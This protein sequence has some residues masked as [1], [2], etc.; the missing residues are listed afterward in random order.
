MEKEC[1]V[2]GKKFVNL[3]VHIRKLHKMSKEDY[4]VYEKGTEIVD[5]DNKEEV[6]DLSENQFK[7]DD[8][9]IV[10][11]KE[12]DIINNVV[13]SSQIE[14]IGITQKELRKNMLSAKEEDPNELLSDF[15]STH[16]VTK[17]EVIELINRYQHGTPIS[18]TQVTRQKMNIYKTQASEIA[19]KNESVL[20]MTNVNIVDYL[21]KEHGYKVDL[22]DRTNPKQ[23]VWVLKK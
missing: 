9:S 17:K 14:D 4:D 22:V 12:E 8:E 19:N 1:K 16:K 7:D 3:T 2:C 10:E 6:L 11:I 5:S 23:K 20:R 13:S 21:C 15:L 18:E